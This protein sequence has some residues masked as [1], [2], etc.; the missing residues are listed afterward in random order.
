[1]YVLNIYNKKLEKIRALRCVFNNIREQGAGRQEKE[2][3]K[4]RTTLYCDILVR[5]DG[6]FLVVLKKIKKSLD[7]TY[8][9]DY[10]Y[11]FYIYYYSD[12]RTVFLY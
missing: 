4:E 5:T 10:R 2:K 6:Y 12:H 8:C 9:T 3:E 11:L 1:M 7:R